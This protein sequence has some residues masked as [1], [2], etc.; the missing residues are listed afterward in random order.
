MHKNDLG[1][2]DLVKNNKN[3]KQKAENAECMKMRM[4]SV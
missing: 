2:K 4:Q 1:K 3:K